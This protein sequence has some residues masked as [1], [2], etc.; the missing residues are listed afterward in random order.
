MHLSS[1]STLLYKTMFLTALYGLP[2]ISELATTRAGH[3][4]QIQDISLDHSKFIITFRSFKHSKSPTKITIYKQGPGQFDPVVSMQRYLCMRGSQ[5]GPLF[6]K[7][8]KS[9]VK[10]D[11]FVKILIASLQYCNLST[12]L[13]K[14]HS[15]RIGGAT[16]CAQLGLSDQLIRRIGRWN[17]NAFVKYITF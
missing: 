8:E 7:E 11:D 10:R 14:C 5:P 13:H 16:F 9:P 1:Y 2:R 15:F 17:S 4:L 6:L 12:T 3:T